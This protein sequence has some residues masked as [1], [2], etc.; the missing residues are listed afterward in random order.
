MATVMN[1]IAV[2]LKFLPVKC[3]C[4]LK[5]QNYTENFLKKIRK[6]FF[7]DSKEE[8]L[9]KVKYYLSEKEERNRIALNGYRKCF[10]AGYDHTSRMKKVLNTIK[11]LA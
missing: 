6:Q 9:E 5:V 7:F 10:D 11:E 2:L 8:L 3:L 1:R 4:L